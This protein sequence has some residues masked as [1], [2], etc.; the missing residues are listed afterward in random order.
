MFEEVTQGY[1]PIAVR[2]DYAG[3]MTISFNT[4]TNQFLV[5]TNGKLAGPYSLDEL[6][7]IKENI[8]DVIE[9]DGMYLFLTKYTVLGVEE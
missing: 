2:D 6:K 3:N 8:S 9:M 7:I 4:E 5:S 1:V